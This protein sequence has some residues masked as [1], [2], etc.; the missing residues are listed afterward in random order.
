MLARLIALAALAL[1]FFA[2]RAGAEDKFLNIYNWS[3]YI[4]AG[5]RAATSRR[6]PASR[7]ITTSMTATRCWRRSF[8]P[9]ASGYDLVVPSASP[10]LARQAQAGV[11]LPID[12]AK[13]KNYGNLDPQILAAAANADPGNRFGVPY[14]WGTTG[15][16]L[17]QGDGEGGARRRRADGQRAPAVRSR[18]RQEAAGLRHLAARQRA[19]DFPGGARLSRPRPV[20]PRPQ[21]SRGAPPPRS[22]RSGPISGSSIPRNTST[23]SPTAISASPGAIR[24]TCSRRATARTRRRTASTSPTPSPRKAR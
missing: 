20:E 23:I 18:Q 1:V 21:G 12:K 17:Q 19:G 5:H 7:S 8:S 15:H 4:A 6:R 2:P 22:R 3:D 10:Y 11:Y 16:R 9:A 24:A 13:L 14:M